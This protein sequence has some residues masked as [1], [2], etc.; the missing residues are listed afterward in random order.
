MKVIYSSKM[1]NEIA[2]VISLGFQKFLFG[3]IR[4]V[5]P[6]VVSSIPNRF[7]SFVVTNHEIFSMAILL[8]LLMYCQAGS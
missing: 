8:L 2:K 3:L 7:H 6:V 5:D 4:I 1:E